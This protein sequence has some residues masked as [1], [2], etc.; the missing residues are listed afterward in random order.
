MI[1]YGA[2][3]YD[4][5][6]NLGDNI[7]TLAALRFLPR[8][9]YWIDR[10]T[11]KIYDTQYN[12]IP[13]DLLRKN[14]IKIKVIYNGWFDSKYSKF[15]LFDVIEPL[16]ISFHI[17]DTN[18]NIDQRYKALDKFILDENNILSPDN[19]LFLKK[20]EPIGCRDLHTLNLLQSVNIKCY[21]S[22]CLTLTLNLEKSFNIDKDLKKNKTLVVDAHIDC[23]N[24]LADLSKEGLNYYDTIT[25]ALNYLE[26]NNNKLVKA[27]TFLNNLY[28][29]D[30]IIT[31]RLHTLLPCIAFDLPVIFVNNNHND[32]RFSGLIKY[33]QFKNKYKITSFIG[34]GNIKNVKKHFY[35]RIFQ[36]I[37]YNPIITINQK[38]IFAIN[39]DVYEIKDVIYYPEKKNDLIVLEKVSD[40]ELKERFLISKKKFTNV[41]VINGIVKSR[42][43]FI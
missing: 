16:F 21:F 25:Q 5:S 39:N 23:S 22:G 33:K 2:L 30:L 27:K 20:Y 4:N 31:S 32:V 37:N 34:P 6:Y 42:F 13:L 18:H 19:Q 40:S 14:K 26:N 35:E 10:D 24:S 15:P 41:I 17:N 1:K 28:N 29:Y 7:Q 43:T 38:Y 9:D 3:C 8:L 12:L 11:C 36:F